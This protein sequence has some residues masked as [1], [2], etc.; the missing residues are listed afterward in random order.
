MNHLSNT[1]EYKKLSC[2]LDTCHVLFY[3]VSILL[4]IKH[5]LKYFEQ[6]ISILWGVWWSI[7]SNKK[8]L[9][10]DHKRGICQIFIQNLK[11]LDMGYSL[12]HPIFFPFIFDARLNHSHS[13]P[14][15]SPSSVNLSHYIL[16][17]LPLPPNNQSFDSTQWGVRPEEHRE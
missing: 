4:Q 7:K 2:N 11:A 10:Q 16:D 17:L 5:T 6:T 3:P 13:N 9:L 1:G 15:I 12:I 8:T 14:I